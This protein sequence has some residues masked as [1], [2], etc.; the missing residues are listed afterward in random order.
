MTVVDGAPRVETIGGAGSNPGELV[1]PV[2]LAWLDNERLV[3][4]DTGNRR[5]QVLDRSGRAF[6]VIELPNA[7]SDFYSRPQIALLTPTR[8]LVSDLPSRSLWLVEEGRP[9]RVDL[10]A[11]GIV[12]SGVASDGER[13]YLSDLEARV[14]R[15]ETAGSSPDGRSPPVPGG[16]GPP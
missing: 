6:E 4:C 10:S 12:P 15:L 2:G 9:R 3:V 1:E 11:T 16:A 14:W 13:V 5:L 7:W 8:W